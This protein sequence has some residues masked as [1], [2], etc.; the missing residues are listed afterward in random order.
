MFCFGSVYAMEKGSK[1]LN[2]FS[3]PFTFSPNLDPSESDSSGHTDPAFALFIA[4]TW[5]EKNI[6][7][8]NNKNE[9]LNEFFNNLYKDEAD[10]E[11]EIDTTFYDTLL[12]LDQE[13]VA[14]FEFGGKNSFFGERPIN[15]RQQREK[16]YSLFYGLSINSVFNG[17]EPLTKKKGV[18]TPDLLDFIVPY[19]NTLCGN[20]LS[21]E[22]NQL[23]NQYRNIFNA[24][25]TS[26]KEQFIVDTMAKNLKVID[27]IGKE[28]GKKIA[29]GVQC[30]DNV[31]LIKPILEKN[32]ALICVAYLPTQEKKLVEC[33]NNYNSSILHFIF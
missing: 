18:L 14:K 28:T 30:G 19:T 12:N 6:P 31:I 13:R 25:T 10:T 1:M 29:L 16:T 7:A 17:C 9:S 33:L 22:I 3:Q 5:P 21:S 4:K 2:P 32:Q 20:S 11:K 24:K 27:F 8:K 15:T 23:K 26:E